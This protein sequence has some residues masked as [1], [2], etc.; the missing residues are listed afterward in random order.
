LWA[1]LITMVVLLIFLALK[2]HKWLGIILGAADRKLS[3]KQFFQLSKQ[4]SKYLFILCL[5]T[6]LLLF[7][8]PIALRLIDYLEKPTGKIAKSIVEH[9]GEI[10][11]SKDLD[12]LLAQ[13]MQRYE[14][15]QYKK[16]AELLDKIFSQTDKRPNAELQGHIF[17][18]YYKAGD[19]ASAAREILRQ[20]RKIQHGIISVG[21]ISLFVLETML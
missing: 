11:G 17:A 14:D 10:L 19:Y 12:R 7:L 3:K 15:E 4:T 5:I 13:A 16:A 18:T 20:D 6:I 2:Y 8:S 21:K 9:E 1:F